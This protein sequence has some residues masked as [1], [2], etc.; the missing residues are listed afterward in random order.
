MPRI[1]ITA[2][3]R[4]PQPYRFQLDRQSVALGRG[5]DN[6]IVVDDGSVSVRHAVMERIEGGYQLRD[7][8]S[9]NGIKLDGSR[10]EIISLRHGLSVKV[11]DVA[12]DFTLTDDERAALNREKPEEQSPIIKED[13][14][15]PLSSSGGDFGDGI[16]KA[17]PASRMAAVV[18]Q[19][20]PHPLVSLLMMI[21]FIALA[22]LAFFIGM[23]LKYKE[24]NDGASLLN[25]IQKQNAA[26]KPADAPAEEEAPKGE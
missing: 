12:F 6:D 11:G 10:K 9:T 5:S 16:R 1:V 15:P 14:L 26:A 21:I 25:A 8:G 20:G 24:K 13:E 3:G 22:A 23:S 18:I 19:R 7:T 4:N 2:P 17:A